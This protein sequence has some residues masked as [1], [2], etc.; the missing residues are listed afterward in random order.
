VVTGGSRGLGLL[1]A[2]E[3]ARAGCRIVI[4]ARNE[5]ELAR[6]QES[7][8]RG[9]AEVL[10]VPCDVS[11]TEDVERLV[12]RAFARFGRIDVLV[13]NAGIIQVGPLASLTREDF[14]RS[15]AVTFWGTV[16]TTLAALPH[17]KARGGRIVNI[18]S[19]GGK[20][21]I[22]RLL[23]YDAAK[24]AVVGFSEGLRAELSP[25]G[26]SVTTIAPGLMRTGSEKFAEHK[27]RGDALWFGTAARLPL[28]TMSP[29]RAAR[30]IF[31]AAVRREAEVVL[32]APAKA[33]SLMHDLAPS[34]KK[35]SK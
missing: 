21:A 29:R 3:F 14:E 34:Q 23:P 5:D 8:S 30:R 2:E 1:I 18:T 28:L 16:N 10:A 13:N 6:A 17:L 32:G 33:L 22:P 24:F 11:R 19:I 31:V 4:C 25:E 35:D 7:L 26:V 9:G 15:L 12:A 20:V 27:T